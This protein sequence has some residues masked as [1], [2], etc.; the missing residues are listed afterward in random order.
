MWFARDHPLS[1]SVDVLGDLR[2]ASLLARAVVEERVD[3]VPARSEGD[4]D[5]HRTPNVQQMMRHMKVLPDEAC[6]LSK[7]H[8]HVALSH[9][10]QPVPAGVLENVA[11]DG[12]RAA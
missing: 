5:N 9:V 12:R 6:P 8:L 1:K 10:H 2:Q 3:W 7:L 11:Q 4:L